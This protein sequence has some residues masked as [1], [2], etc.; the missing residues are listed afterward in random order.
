MLGEC[1]D[2]SDS[3]D[4]SSPLTALHHR[5]L[6]IRRFNIYTVDAA[7]LHTKSTSYAVDTVSLH[8]KPT[9]IVVN[10]ASHVTIQHL[11]QSIQHRYITSLPQK[12]TGGNTQLR[13][14]YT[15]KFSRA[16]PQT[17]YATITP[18]S[19]YFIVHIDPALNTAAAD[20]LHEAE[21]LL[22]S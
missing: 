7:S 10:I 11:L 12:F 17:H 9:S 3:S 18:A 22:R 6:F 14:R 19:L 15:P 5:H 13:H 2:S 4:S 16:F 20:Q 8:N 21:S 1:N